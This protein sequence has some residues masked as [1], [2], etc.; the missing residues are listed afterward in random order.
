MLYLAGS[1][2]ADDPSLEYAEERG[3]VKRIS[4]K[5][6]DKKPVKKTTKKK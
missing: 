5:S 6:E 4:V 1:E 2:I 3:L